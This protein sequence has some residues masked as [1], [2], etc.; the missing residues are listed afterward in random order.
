MDNPMLLCFPDR[1]ANHIIGHLYP[2][3]KTIE[4]AKV[5]V[6]CKQ[7]MLSGNNT[8]K[9]DYMAKSMYGIEDL[10][11]DRDTLFI[12]YLHHMSCF[13][14][15]LVCTNTYSHLDDILLLFKLKIVEIDVV[16]QME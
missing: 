7:F 3:K 1:N 13:I 4:S 16:P 5:V 11:L 15:A 10:Y 14:T 8:C 6:N 9:K 2:E 12:L